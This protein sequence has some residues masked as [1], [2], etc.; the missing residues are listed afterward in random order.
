MLIVYHSNKLESLK[1]SLAEIIRDKSLRDPFQS[2]V[3]LIQNNYI[4]QWLQIEL[5]YELGIVC[6]INF[7]DLD[8]YF[9]KI[10]ID[11]LENVSCINYFSKPIMIWKLMQIISDVSE[12]TDCEIIKHYLLD[13]QDQRKRFQL[14]VHIAD[15]FIKYLLYRPDWLEAWQY[16]K[17][18]KALG[19]AQ[20]WQA[21]LWRELI[22]HTKLNRHS[23]I[24]YGSLYKKFISILSN[25][26]QVI[27]SDFSQRI[28]IFSVS[29]LVPVYYKILQALSYHIDIYLFFINPNLHYLDVF[30]DYESTLN[31]VKYNFCNYQDTKSQ[32]FLCNKNRQQKLLFN[33]NYYNNCCCLESPLLFAW[34]ES[35]RH[36]LF[37]LSRLKNVRK[38]HAFVDCVKG[39]LLNILQ[40]DILNFENHINMFNIKHYDDFCITQ[41]NKRLLKP[42][43]Y[44]LCLHGCH[45]IQHEVEVLYNNLL[46]VVSNDPSILP[47]EIIVMMPNIDHYIPAIQ[48]IFGTAANKILP[49]IIIDQKWKN[50]HPILLIFFNLLKLPDIR[51]TS[52]EIFALLET[53]SIASHFG[54]DEKKLELLHYW[55]IDSG[56]CWG[57]D[58][59]TFSKL[60][61]PIVN[62]YT[63]HFGLNRMLLGYAIDS[64]YGFWK[65][66]F[67]YNASSG[68]QYIELVGQLGF[69]LEKLRFW[70]NE[71]TQI[72]ILSEWQP[73]IR[74]I[75]DDFF[76]LSI[77][78]EE[79]F[80]LLESNWHEFVEN[81]KLANYHQ[82]ISIVLIRDYLYSKLELRCISQ[83]F[84]SNG[85]NFCN[86]S[87]HSFIPFKVICLL[88]MNDNVYPRNHFEFDFNLMYKQKR[89]GDLDLYNKDYYLFLEMILSAQ[90]LLYI[91]FIYCSIY[92]GRSLYPSVLIDK[93]IEYI[94][95][96]FSLG[97]D[98]N[99]GNISMLIECMRARLCQWHDRMPF[100]VE[101]LNTNGVKQQIFY[102]T[103]LNTGSNIGNMRYNFVFSLDR[104]SP[105]ILLLDDLLN[106]YKSP[107]K[108]WFKERLLVNLDR[109]I[110][111]CSEDEPFFVDALTRYKLNKYLLNYFIHNKKTSDINDLYNRIYATGLLPYGAFGELYWLQQ[112]EKMSRLADKIIKWYLPDQHDMEVSLIINDVKL[113]GL[114]RAVQ[115]NGLLRWRPA[116]LSMRDGLLLWLEHLVYCVIDDG[117]LKNSSKMFGINSQWIFPVIPK[118]LAK[119][120]LSILFKGYYDGM[121]TPL[122][123]LNKSV[124]VWL[125]Y[126]FDKNTKNIILCHDRQY[127]ARLKLIECWKGNKYIIGES[128]DPYLQRLLGEDINSLHIELIID[129]AK[130]YYLPIMKFNDIS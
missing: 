108:T 31:L 86:F 109:N 45:S 77:Q 102:D 79:A 4:S 82:P 35:V 3:I 9:W 16:N 21:K 104:M 118:M 93:L 76:D 129:I 54:F 121:S 52:K 96:N 75:I 59:L 32:F 126:C 15:L 34:G 20:L 11:T 80:L 41:Q 53:P 81:G 115:S 91:S 127:N 100:L 44:S 95:Q 50:I 67:P 6:N 85:I 110:I 84:L 14:S 26:H 105:D 71:L 56:I 61:V 94:A 8:D 103:C 70:R 72:K 123:L 113:T 90:Q 64:K 48:S 130:F 98:E 58:D 28:F 73:C 49:F 23:L 39:S 120:Y 74:K 92:D 78:E 27:F 7:F 99:K 25:N 2:E 87:S 18:I 97:M 69:F 60:D 55:I 42:D 68:Q 43:D 114:L 47:H 117:L 107:I 33:D 83:K 116:V 125:N 36:D 30:F 63:W 24:N 101:C 51:C 65:G 40:Q 5:A 122:L 22:I 13:D 62:Q 89:C 112:C 29:G 37:F 88:G 1:N 119:E 106:F 17:E 111:E 66:I 38:V 10:C 19:K 124:G 57:L 12:Q 128:H 46:S